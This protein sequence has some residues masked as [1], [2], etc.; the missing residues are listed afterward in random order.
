MQPD[1][2]VTELRAVLAPDSLTVERRWIRAG[3]APTE[4]RPLT[5]GALN[6]LMAKGDVVA[7]WLQRNGVLHGAWLGRAPDETATFGR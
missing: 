1:Q 3:E 6:L 7:S 2:P 5:I 4:W